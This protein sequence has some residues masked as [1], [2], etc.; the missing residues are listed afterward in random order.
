[1]N[2]KGYHYWIAEVSIPEERPDGRGGTMMQNYNR[3]FGVIAKDMQQA[4]ALVVEQAPTSTVHVLRKGEHW[5]Y[6][7][8]LIDP[9]LLAFGGVCDQ[10]EGDR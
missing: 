3:H 8:L 9:V 7:G 6:G 4:L 1:M 2:A 5:G 10:T